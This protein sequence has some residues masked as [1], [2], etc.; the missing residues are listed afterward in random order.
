VSE[1]PRGF[2]EFNLGA[3]LFELLFVIDGRIGWTAPK[4]LKAEPGEFAGTQRVT[5]FL[6][7]VL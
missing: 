7:H 2:E 1:S 3:T 6:T 4:K 5:G